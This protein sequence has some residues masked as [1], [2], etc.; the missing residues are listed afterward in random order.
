MCTERSR[1][2]KVMA[3]LYHGLD[4]LSFLPPRLSC[5]GCKL[6]CQL[7]CLLLFLCKACLL[8]RGLT[9]AQ[10]VLLSGSGKVRQLS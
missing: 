7:H 3:C 9:P 2:S 6:R 8:L 4:A 1:E 10:H 5:L